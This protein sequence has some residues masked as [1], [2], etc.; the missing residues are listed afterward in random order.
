M[1]QTIKLIKKLANIDNKE[2]FKKLTDKDIINTIELDVYNSDNRILDGTL[3]QFQFAHYLN[4]LFLFYKF[5]D[6]RIE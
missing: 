5:Y 6:R 3:Y 1:A 2:K 4:H